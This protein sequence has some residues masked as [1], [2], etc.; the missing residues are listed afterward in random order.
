M[1]DADSTYATANEPQ[2]VP[3][4]SRRRL[5]ELAEDPD[6]PTRLLKSL[7]LEPVDEVDLSCLNQLLHSGAQGG[8]RLQFVIGGAEHANRAQLDHWRWRQNDRTLD[9]VLELTNVARPI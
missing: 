4:W 8:A 6:A 1:R 9:G 2:S 7:D 3:A 5:S